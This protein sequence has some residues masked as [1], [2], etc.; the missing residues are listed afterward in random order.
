[1]QQ[2]NSKHISAYFQCTQK[3]YLL[4]HAVNPTQLTE[5]ESLVLQAQERVIKTYERSLT[6]VQ[7]YK[8][9]IFSR[10]F[11]SI[12]NVKMSVEGFDFD[13]H[14]LLKANTKS[15]LGGFSYEPVIFL[16]TSQIS[17][18]HRLELAFSGLLLEKIQKKFP[19]K[20]LIIDK[21]GIR[22]QIELKKFKKQVTGAIQ[23]IQEFDQKPPKLLLNKHCHQCSFEKTCRLKAIQ[24]DNLSLLER[25]TPKQIIKLEK[26]GIFTVKQLSFTY[27][28]RRR[29]KQSQNPP[30]TFKPELQ[31]LAIRTEKTY[32]QRLPNLERKSIELF[33]DIEGIPDDGFFYL[34]GVVISKNLNREYQ[35]FW[36]ATPQDEKTSW[37]KVVHLLESYPESPIYH[38]GTFEPSSFDKLSKRY[39]TNIETI[40][41]RFINVNS[42]IYGKI[43]FPAYSNGL[44][45]LGQILGVQW[46]DKQASGLQTIIWRNY[47]EQGKEEFQDRLLIYNQEDCLALE[48]LT[49]ELT[50]IQTTASI[51]NDIDFVQS[52]KKTASAVSQEVHNQFKSILEFSHFSHDK[53]KIKFNLDKEEKKKLPKQK[54]GKK[55]HQG[56][57]KEK[58]RITKTISL[59]RDEFCFKHKE[60]QLIDSPKISTRLIIDIVFTQD[61]VQKTV[62]EYIGENGYCSICYR[63]RPTKKIRDI[64]RLSLYGYNFK[65]WFVF[66]RIALQLPYEKIAR[67]IN[68]LF[69]EEMSWRY[70]HRFIRDFSEYHEI[71]E[72]NIVKKLLESPYIHVDETPI[73]IQG[74]TQYVWVFT[75][76]EYVILRLSESREIEIAR[77]FLENYKGVLISDFFA[78][79]DS[80][81]CP[82]QKC[83]VHFIRDLNENLW[84]NPFDKEYEDFVS[85]IRNLIVPII[86]TV[87]KRGLKKYFLAKYRKN[88]DGFYK[89]HIDNKVYKSEPCKLYQKRLIRYRNSLFTFIEH[90]NISWH[91]NTAERGLRH[92]C[93]QLSISGSLHQTLTPHYLRLVSILQTCRFQGKSFFKFLLSKERDIDEFIVEQKIT[94]V[95][96]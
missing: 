19:D 40:R 27:K 85:E 38:Y 66:Q 61:G 24:E 39:Q 43:Y 93:K 12:R 60:Q 37:Q 21:N 34:F 92:I 72:Q 96:E 81:N 71:T 7:D 88:I 35:S 36:S 42:F 78:G 90:D 44:K 16:G 75:S 57:R 91:N 9:G 3:A 10:G 76:K 31:A 89:K 30:I 74:K 68:E 46:T 15:S 56:Q 95:D 8:D 11:E 33:L 50:R 26:K 23:D 20:G 87:H 49:N 41:K 4:F 52:P 25:I 62:T 79:Y 73:N 2:I 84:N 13:S 18:E 65:A 53:R 54:I 64:P 83:W 59:R 17:K 82:Q 32:I 28:P 22:H 80:L 14:L 70:A 1:M 48:T 77:R 58:P 45:H 55:V 94:F 69:Q 6:G 29:S 67:S 63:S 47:W 5:Y 51:S 86:Q